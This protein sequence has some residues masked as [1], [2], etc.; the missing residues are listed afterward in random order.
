[1]R[2]G[3]CLRQKRVTWGE[4]SWEMIGEMSGKRVGRLCVCVGGGGRGLYGD[5]CGRL[6]GDDCGGYGREKGGHAVHFVSR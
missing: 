1:M 3:E 6:W 4:G 5:G 2:L